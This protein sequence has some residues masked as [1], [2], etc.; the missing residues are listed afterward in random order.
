MTQKKLIYADKK[1]INSKQSAK[2]CV[3]QKFLHSI[4]IPYRRA[5]VHSVCFVNRTQM[6]QK[7]L[8]YADKNR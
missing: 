7:K 6:T 3:H 8:I 1:Q 2:I 4:F 5:A